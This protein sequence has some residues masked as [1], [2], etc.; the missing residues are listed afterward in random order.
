TAKLDRDLSSSCLDLTKSSGEMAHTTVSSPSPPLQPHRLPKTHPHLLP[1]RLLASRPL[2]CDRR[3][4]F[5][6]LPPSHSSGIPMSLFVGSLCET[7]PTGRRTKCCAPAENKGC[8]KLSLSNINRAPGLRK[9]LCDLLRNHLV[10]LRLTT[11]LATYP[12][13]SCLDPTKSSGEMAHTT[14]SSLSPPHQPNPLPKTP[15]HP[16]LP[17]TLPS[18]PLNS[19][20]GMVC[21]FRPLDYPHRL[22]S[23]QA[24]LDFLLRNHQVSLRLTTNLATYRLSSCLDPSKSSGE[25]AHTT[26]SSPSPPNQPHP[27]PKP[28]HLPLLPRLL[29]SEPVEAVFGRDFPFVASSQRFSEAPLESL[30]R[31]HQVSIRLTANL[32]AYLSLSCLDLTKSSGEMAHTTV[33]SPSP[34]NQPHPLPKTPHPPLLARLLPSEPVEAVFGRVSIRL[35]ANLAAYLS[36]SCLDLTKSSG[37]MAHTTVSSPSPPNQPHPLPKTPHPPLLPRLLAS[38]PVEAVF[39]RGQH[40]SPRDASS[41]S[42]Y[43]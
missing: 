30:L 7:S 41:S 4:L 6:V 20:R 9:H 3:R 12:S 11:N 34:P 19:D 23:S 33:S 18:E 40:I 14:V 13:L 17:R 27:L 10:S 24:P 5:L 15:P 16:L 31:N 29:A 43:A 8:G 42:P 32:A 28:P 39:G 2:D 21:G 35:T 25:M 22:G 38:E 36:L 37:E 26:V 1:P